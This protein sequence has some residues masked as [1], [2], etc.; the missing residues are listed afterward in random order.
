LFFFLVYLNYRQSAANQKQKP[1]SYHH[2]NNTHAQQTMEKHSTDYYEAEK[3]MHKT[4]P[5]VA[6]Q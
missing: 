4:K 2:E 3:F 6:D 1:S 5:R